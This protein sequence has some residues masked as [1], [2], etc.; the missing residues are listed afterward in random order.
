M[1][2][3]PLRIRFRSPDRAYDLFHSFPPDDLDWIEGHSR[4]RDGDSQVMLLNLSSEAR[5]QDFRRLC[6][7]HP[8]IVEVVSITEDEFWRAPSNAI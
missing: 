6:A 2:I 1:P 3:F 7:E 4:K 8:D 5:L